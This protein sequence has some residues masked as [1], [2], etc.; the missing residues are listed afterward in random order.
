MYNRQNKFYS[1]TP[2]NRNSKY[3]W[4]ITEILRDVAYR[5]LLINI[6]RIKDKKTW[7]HDSKLKKML[8]QKA[9]L[10]SLG[11]K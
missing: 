3:N 8:A 6:D 1:H 2:L 7:Y 9:H 10:E 5:E 4:R 11:C